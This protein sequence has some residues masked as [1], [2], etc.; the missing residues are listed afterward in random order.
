MGTLTDPYFSVLS[1]PSLRYNHY[2]FYSDFRSKL[3]AVLCGDGRA[4]KDTK[5]YLIFLLK[6]A[7]L[8]LTKTFQQLVI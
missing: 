1:L 6:N 2:I 5:F 8:V 7:Y 3:N 4:D